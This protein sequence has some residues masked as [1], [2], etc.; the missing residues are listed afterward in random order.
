MRIAQL[1]YLYKPALGGVE[2]HT[3][4]ISKY[5]KAFGN[6]VDIYTSDFLSLNCKDRIHLKKEIIDNI[7]INRKK[8]FVLPVSPYI[9]RFLFPTV[10]FELLK[11]D[12][13]I[14]H[15]QSIP[16]N[17]YDIAWFISKIKKTPIFITAHYS[18]NDLDV[19]YGS[20]LRSLYWKIWMKYSLKRVTKL[21]A[22]V[23]SEK[24]RFVKY[25]DI[26]DEQIVVIPNGIKLEEFDNIKE[27]DVKKFQEK[28][29][30]YDKRIILNVGRITRV[31]GTDIL[32]MAS[33]PLLKEYEGLGL[34]I[35][36]P[37]QDEQYYQS[38]IEL[39]KQYN[40]EKQII[41]TGELSRKD[42]LSAYKSCLIVVLPSRGEVFGITLVEGM[43]LKKVVIGSDSGGIPDVIE[44]NKTGL[45]FKSENSED[46]RRTLQYTLDNYSELSTIRENAHDVV[47]R[48]YN[49][50]II[51]KQLNELYYTSL[52]R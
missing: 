35:I 23:D 1:C 18:P 12:Y 19:V 27:S 21:V 47:K 14:I 50:K 40:L 42:V 26:P 3:E 5:L 11:K 44:N 9:Q 33:A 36:G 37:I 46:L 6:D 13:D 41:I 38:L 7:S 4:N 51:T 20:R 16:S 30:F 17:H 48:K 34:L 39:V 8:G 2:Y 10:I 24:E 32:I 25:W 52:K 29:G 45:L 15:V 43:Y 22:I 31:K 49:W 28:H